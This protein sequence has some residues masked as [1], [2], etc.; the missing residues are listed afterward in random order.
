[1]GFTPRQIDQWTPAEYNACVEGWIKAHDPEGREEL[2][3][4][5]YDEFRQ[6]MDS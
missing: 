3:T 6:F 2:P 4:L 5:T 1:M